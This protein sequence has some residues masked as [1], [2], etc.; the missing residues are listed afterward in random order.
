MAMHSERLTLVQT[1]EEARRDAESLAGLPAGTLAAVF[2]RRSDAVDAAVQLLV[3]DADALVWVRS[4]DRAA[5]AIRAA[6]SERGLAARLL[7]GFGDEELLVRDVLRQAEYGHTVLV[8]RGQRELAGKL[9]DASHIYQFGT[10]T[11]RPV[12]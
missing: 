5:T 9:Q 2:S 4:G 10:W 3:D 1:K 6:R 12:R 8:V 11:I 7:R